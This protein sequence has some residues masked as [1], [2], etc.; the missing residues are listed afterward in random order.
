[1][2]QS[3]PSHKLTSFNMT[4]QR[5][6]VLLAS[7][8]SDLGYSQV[9]GNTYGAFL[10]LYKRVESGLVLNLG[11]QSSRLFSESFS[12]SFYLSPTF[13]WGYSPP[14]FPCGAY[15][16]I[17]QF[18]RT[19]ERARLLAPE[20]AKPGVRDAWWT[21]YSE[22]NVRLFCEALALVESRF[23]EQK[24]MIGAVLKS[25]DLMKHKALVT[26]VIELAEADE[27][28]KTAI[29]VPL[30]ELEVYALK[31]LQKSDPERANKNVQR[32]LALD[33]FRC[34]KHGLI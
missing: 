21:P 17:G 11:M 5:L 19:D 23:L 34:I 26:A 6:S 25:P 28:F 30:P 2:L 20:Y 13:T 22:D 7:S 33:A 10:H 27:R 32:F 29:E 1:M 8:I 3:E 18:L 12:S 16:R 4:R 31:S 9:A 24:E 15:V 14:T